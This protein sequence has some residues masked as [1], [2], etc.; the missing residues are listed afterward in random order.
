[1]TTLQDECVLC[2]TK[3][4][5][6]TITLNSPETGNVINLSNL[7]LLRDG[8]VDALASDDCRLIVIRGR[9]GVFCKGMDF[10]GF[11]DDSDEEIARSYT[12]PYK[13]ILSL[14]HNSS[15][16]VIAYVDG[17]VLAGGMGLALICD[18]VLATRNST[19]GLSEV[20]FGIIPAFVTPVLLMRVPLKK[21]QYLILSSKR[22]DTVEAYNLGIVDELMEPEK[23]E[24]TLKN[25]I[26]RVLYSS[27]KALAL[28]KTFSNTI[29]GTKF[30]TAVEM[31]QDQL[32][33]LLND[34][35]SAR[36][37]ASFLE[38]DKPEWAVPYK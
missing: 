8:L 37:I 30:E 14:I 38:G 27:P 7:V 6:T 28:T 10:K 21:L 17:E 2:E 1:M 31:A 5:V 16:P 15:K 33:E 32:T 4:Y 26:R 29:P 19:F 12:D 20:L 25:Y 13:D 35:S 22:F 36:A 3:S 18:M 34:E 24:R 23:A 9:D 11:L